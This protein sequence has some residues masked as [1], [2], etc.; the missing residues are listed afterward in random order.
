MCGILEG[1]DII[2][3]RVV[4]IVVHMT[5]CVYLKLQ[6][7]DD[8]HICSYLEHVQLLEVPCCAD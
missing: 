6:R 4:M 5:V 7:L 1:R 2:N 8:V 3:F